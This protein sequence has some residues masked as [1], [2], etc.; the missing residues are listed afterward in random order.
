M[1]EVSFTF[2]SFQLPENIWFQVLLYGGQVVS[3]KN[4][5]KEELL[6]MSS[7]VNKDYSFAFS[8]YKLN[9]LTEAL[10]LF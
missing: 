10:L 9:Q 7:K 1:E 2:S 6:F 5:R 8:T 3:W 4:E